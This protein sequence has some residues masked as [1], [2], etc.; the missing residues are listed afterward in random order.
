MAMCHCKERSSEEKIPKRVSSNMIGTPG[1]ILFSDNDG[2]K[3]GFAASTEHLY[4]LWACCSKIN[5]RFPSG[6]MVVLIP[7]MC[8][9]HR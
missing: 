5:S 7:L 6:V 1:P 8:S 2:G 4:R 9:I 3:A